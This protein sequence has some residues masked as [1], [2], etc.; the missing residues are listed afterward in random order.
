MPEHKLRLQL[1]NPMTNCTQTPTVSCM[2]LKTI[3]PIAT[4]A[5]LL[6]IGAPLFPTLLETPVTLQPQAQGLLN[7][8]GLRPLQPHRVVSHITHAL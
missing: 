8:E 6:T 5:P 3:A 7:L 1:L 2:I 4:I